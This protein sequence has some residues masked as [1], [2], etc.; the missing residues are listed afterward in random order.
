MASSSV[1]PEAN[2]VSRDGIVGK[3][4]SDFAL[5]VILDTKPDD[6]ILLGQL[7]SQYIPSYQSGADFSEKLRT[8]QAFLEAV[9]AQLE[10]HKE[11]I[12]ILQEIRH[13]AYTD[14]KHY[15]ALTAPIRSIPSE[16]LREIFILA[17]GTVSIPL[18]LSGASPQYDDIYNQVPQPAITP[19][20]ERTALAHVCH[21]WR[22]VVVQECHELWSDV[23]FSIS[24]DERWNSRDVEFSQAVLAWSKPSLLSVE[25]TVEH[26]WAFPEQTLVLID[27]SSV[28]CI[29]QMLVTQQHRWKHLHVPDDV[30]NLFHLDSKVLESL[31][32]VRSSIGAGRMVAPNLFELHSIRKL[33]LQGI[34]PPN[35]KVLP[36]ITD[37]V[38]GL[39]A[40]TYSFLR[41]TQLPKL[42]SLSLSSIINDADISSFSAPNLPTLQY[43]N[44]RYLNWDR[45]RNPSLH[46]AAPSLVQLSL[47]FEMGNDCLARLGPS[48]LPIFPCLLS[49]RFT[50]KYCCEPSIEELLKAMGYILRDM[51]HLKFLDIT[52]S[53]SW[54]V[55][56]DA[57][58]DEWLS[59]N[60]LAWP[61]SST[62]IDLGGKS[63]V[64]F[65]ALESLKLSLPVH[66][67]PVTKNVMSSLESR[68][69]MGHFKWLSLMQ[70]ETQ[71]INFQKVSLSYME[72]DFE[73]RLERLQT[74]G[75][76]V[77][78]NGEVA[79]FLGSDE[80]F[81]AWAMKSV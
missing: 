17:C 25:F 55:R 18:C 15:S 79:Q 61:L 43:L 22:S 49:F 40:S 80:G 50:M 58:E 34:D 39:S 77:L 74:C 41:D 46:L 32:V 21:G 56:E 60:L 70:A 76:G 37:L 19:V 52:F 38:L 45:K 72:D 36:H 14:Y 11:E 26:L 78:L 10:F 63:R 9:D 35:E 30:L 13:R 31:A 62:P 5:D 8:T 42:T 33:S 68:W 59:S 67:I 7:R 64:L 28:K 6:L 48:W 54:S 75:L 53:H 2:V 69:A 29:F 20:L 12:N 23:Q 1:V 73:E 16:I 27:D 47:H 81:E 24:L 65:P 66:L 57:G 3:K 4:S 71:G 44:L 51:E